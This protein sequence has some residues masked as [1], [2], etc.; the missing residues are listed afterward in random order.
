LKVRRAALLQALTVV[1]VAF[2]ARGRPLS[3]VEVAFLAL[4]FALTAVEVSE[5]GQKGTEMLGN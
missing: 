2:R 5:T 1:E 3:G 4:L